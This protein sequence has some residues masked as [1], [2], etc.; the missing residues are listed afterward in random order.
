MNSGLLHGLKLCETDLDGAMRRFMGDEA[1]YVSCLNTFL[2]DRTMQ[3]LGDA[4]AQGAWDEAFTAVHALKGLAGNMGFVP[5]SHA[6]GEL[7]L[8]IRAGRI[9]EIN[10]ALR[11]VQRCYNDVVAV[12]RKNHFIAG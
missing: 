8:L 6:A 10:D 12:I 4:I 11:D 3:A 5:L 9:P 2:E 1:F 7:V